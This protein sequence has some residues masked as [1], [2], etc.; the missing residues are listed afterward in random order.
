MCVL[1]T[2]LLLTG[3]KDREQH[4]ALVWV[5]T[6]WTIAQKDHSWH[7]LVE[8]WADYA[9]NQTANQQHPQMALFADA[10]VVVAEQVVDAAGLL[11]VL[12]SS[13]LWFK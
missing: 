6:S 12:I 7:W 8:V 11:V 1:Y 9:P 4:L 3:R 13:T 2:N 10:A 5:A